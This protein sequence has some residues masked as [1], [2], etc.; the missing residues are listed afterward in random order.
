M[1]QGQPAKYVQ[2]AIRNQPGLWVFN[3]CFLSCRLE[4]DQIQ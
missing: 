1:S 2:D 4:S 3:K